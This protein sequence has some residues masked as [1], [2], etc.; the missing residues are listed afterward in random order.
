ML[1]PLVSVIVPSYNHSEYI[2]DCIESIINQS[3]LDIEL[4]VIDDGS[5]DGSPK[6]VERMTARCTSRFLR[7]ECRSRAN[8]GLLATLNEGLEW[9]K[10]SFVCA[11]ASD[12]I[13]LEEKTAL[14]VDYLVNNPDVVAVFGGITL[15][16]IGGK[17][18]RTVSRPGL[19]SFE[20]IFM[21]RHF[22][23]APTA[24][25]RLDAV[26]SIGYDEDI[27]IEDWYMWL[28]LSK[29]GRLEALNEV[30][31]LYRQHGLNMSSSGGFMYM[32]GM[33]ILSRFSSFA[34]YDRAVGQYELAMA[35]LLA[36]AD[37]RQAFVHFARHCKKRHI[38]ARTL[39][40][41]GK[42]LCPAF[43]LA[44]VNR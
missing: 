38:G 17:H 20:D 3:Y 28:R 40:V 37:K 16:D 24:M 43:I 34:G 25:M 5:T 33:K 10:G 36:S 42:I 29:Y 23:P 13:W 18:L 9:C 2:Q 32:E 11:L 21:H 22:L 27:K 14:Q 8:K 26:K 7:F 1:N 41:L 30:V 39:V 35:A 19:Y 6:L 4:I 31:S 15:I 44:R 12:D